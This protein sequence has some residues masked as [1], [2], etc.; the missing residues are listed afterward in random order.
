MHRRCRNPVKFPENC[1]FSSAATYKTEL[2]SLRRFWQPQRLDSPGRLQENFAVA[3]IPGKL[4][5]IATSV[6]GQ[7]PRQYQKL[8]AN[9]FYGGSRIIVRQAQ[10]L[11]PMDEVVRQKQQLQEGHV[12]HPTLRRNFIQGKILE[13]F[14]ERLFR[15]GSRLVSLPNHPGL[16]LQVGHESRVGEPAH[17]QQ[18]QLLGLLGVFGQRSSH[19]DEAVLRFPSAR[20][21]TKLC[22]RPA[23]GHFLEASLL[24][25]GQVELGLGA[26]NNIAAAC[27]VQITH[28]LSRKESRVGQQTNPGSCHPRRNFFHTAADQSAGPRVGSR[29]AG[30]QRAVP[31]LL[32]VSFKA[33]QRMIGGASFLPG[34]VAHSGALLLSIERED[35]RV[36]VEDQTRSRLG[37]GGQLRPELNMQ[38]RELPESFSREA[39]QKATQGGFVRKF[40]KADQ[41]KKQSIVMEDLGFVHAGQSSDQNIEKHQEQIGR[42]IIGPI[43]RVLENAFQSAAQT[44]LVTKALDQEQT[45]EVRER[46]RLERKIQCLQAFS[47]FAAKKKQG[48]GTAPIT[49][50]N[51]RFLAHNQNTQI[52][53][54][55]KPLKEKLTVIDAFLRFQRWVGR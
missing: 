43:R 9:C 1:T 52:G 28:Q 54:R 50:Q 49:V 16:Q 47:H 25:Q 18:A 6:R 48:F 5:H 4:Q 13:E 22:H 46:V 38:A 21:K 40:L 30:A 51:G 33:Q 34:I 27:L 8:V 14:P 32:A 29:V 7:F 12:G 3:I 41:R 24:G 45:T 36:E 2:F 19:H 17:L 31:K 35:H 26:N 37:Q 15:V 11:K 20:L 53:P 10:P 42:M 23:K 39:A 44:E 55:D